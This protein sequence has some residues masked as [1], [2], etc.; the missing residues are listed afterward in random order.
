MRAGG[1][2]SPKYFNQFRFT[3]IRRDMTTTDYLLIPTPA[4]CFVLKVDVLEAGKMGFN[5]GQLV[6][7]RLVCQSVSTLVQGPGKEQR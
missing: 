2:S 6:M 4:G 7:T 1:T 3:L 5:K